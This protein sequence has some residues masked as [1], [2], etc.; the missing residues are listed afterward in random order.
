MEGEAAGG[1]WPFV[2][3][4]DEVA[5]IDADGRGA[6]LVGVAGVGK[7]RLLAEVL[8]GDRAQQSRAIRRTARGRRGATRMSPRSAKSGTTSA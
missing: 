5:L 1:L 8:A 3:R 7:T 2:A 6:V 4:S